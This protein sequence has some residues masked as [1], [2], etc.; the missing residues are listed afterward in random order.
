MDRSDFRSPRSERPDGEFTLPADTEPR[1]GAYDMSSD[2]IVP[3][4]AS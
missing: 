1:A 3:C 2:K 4:P